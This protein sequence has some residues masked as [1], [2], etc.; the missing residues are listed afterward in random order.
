MPANQKSVGSLVLSTRL[1]SEGILER[2][3]GGAAPA[4]TGAEPWSGLQLVVGRLAGLDE[5]GQ[6]LFLPD[7]PSRAPLPVAIATSESDEVLV[8]A[9]RL[10]QRALAALVENSG[11][12][13]LGLL[14]EHIEG[15]ARDDHSEELEVVVD[16]EKLALRAKRQIELRCGKAS[17]VLR[18]DGRVVLSGT[19]VVS[20]SRGPNKIMGATIA[21]N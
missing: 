12:V 13:L 15:R 18:A 21:L 14:R 10:N 11:P 2:M 9:A 3:M 19:Y 1:S 7:G 20:T 6:L 8:K 16:G 4:T 5:K 17:L